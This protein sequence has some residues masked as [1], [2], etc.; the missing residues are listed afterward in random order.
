MGKTSTKNTLPIKALSYLLIYLFCFLGLQVQHMEVPR[1]WIE[2][3]LQLPTYT[4]A[5]AMG[6]PSCDCEPRHS[7]RQCQILNPLSEARDQ[8]HILMDPSRVHYC[9]A[10]RG[11]P[12]RSFRVNGE[13]KSFNR[14]AKAKRIQLHQ[15]TFP[16][17]AK[18]MSLG[19]KEKERQLETRKL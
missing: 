11:T 9:W 5:S 14:Q 4:T 18:G 10:M 8:T 16:T 3:K 13:I 6:D 17:N 12:R 1:L 2:P 19:W 7:S 15:T